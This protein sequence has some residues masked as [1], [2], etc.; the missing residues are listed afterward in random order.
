M[1]VASAAMPK[2]ELLRW[3]EF[4]RLHA[5]EA[6]DVRGLPVRVPRPISFIWAFVGGAA[7]SA[8]VDHGAAGHQIYDA[9][10]ERPLVRLVESISNEAEGLVRFAVPAGVARTSLPTDGSLAVEFSEVDG[11][12]ATTPVVAA[13]VGADLNRSAPWPVR[14][15][16]G[17]PAGTLRIGDTRGLTPYAG[18]GVLTEKKLPRP[19]AFRSLARCLVSPGSPFDGSL[20]MTDFTFA[21][22]AIYK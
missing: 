4:C 9:N 2:A 7:C 16:A 11:M 13:A 8:F 22:Q 12:V 6:R 18:G 17:D 5:L 14:S 10:G 15:R 20:V 3:N 21:Q 1:V 19:S